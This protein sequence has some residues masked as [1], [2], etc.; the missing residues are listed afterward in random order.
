MQPSMS[1]P[2]PPRQPCPSCPWRLDPDARSIP[3]FSLELAQALAATC[4]DARNLGPDVGAAMF[5]CHQSKA[6]AEV[7]C[8]G[9]LATVGPG[10][11]G[12]R[13]SITRGRLDLS[14]LEAGP[15]WPPLHENYGQVLEKLRAT[16][17]SEVPAAGMANTP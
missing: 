17:D 10:H 12:V 9:W 16:A 13:L 4:P 7:H 14:H 11:P 5:A 1:A 3:N 2:K 15:D 6:G 8:A